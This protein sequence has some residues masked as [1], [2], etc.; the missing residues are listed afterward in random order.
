MNTR[1][2]AVNCGLLCGLLCGLV[3]PAQAQLPEVRTPL[4]VGTKI[5]P[6]FAMKGPDG[7][8]TGISIKLWEDLAGQLKLDYRYQELSLE[9]LLSGVRSN[10]LDVAVAAITV[11]SD[12]ERE[13]DFTHPFYITGLGI[14]VSN[15]NGGGA[16]W[17]AVLR[18]VLS[19][20]F[21]A[22]IGLL[23]LLLIGVGFM[24]WLFERRR[25]AE[26]FGGKP[27]HGI[28]S[29]FWWSAVTMTTVGYGDKAPRTFGGRLIALIWMFTGIIIISS[30]TAA[31][32][33]ALTVSKLGSPIRGPA[34]LAGIRVAAIADS[35]GELYLKGRQ[36]SYQQ[37]PDAL[38]ALRA[39][40]EARVDAVVY[41]APILKYLAKEEFPGSIVVLP[42]TFARQDYAIAVPEGSP[43]RET[44]DRVLEKKIRSPQWQEV[45]NHFLGP[46]DL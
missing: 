12:R 5:A 8:W 9:D 6:P 35:T 21:L 19:P 32:T 1:A 36:I 18:R 43:L 46:E 17:L 24:I 22:V 39:L 20:Q 40:D 11:T 27:L 7:K 28:G 14:A 2:W 45:L 38:E 4:I 34:D 33:S 30:F 10:S 15:P 37:Y 13:M 31:I 41:D 23:A 29:G 25:N 42:K 44:L 26:H 3:A 16:P